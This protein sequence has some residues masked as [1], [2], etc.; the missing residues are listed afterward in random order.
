[1]THVH[2]VGAGLAGL[3]AAVAL[4]GQGRRVTLYEAAAHAGG[5]CRSFY[6]RTLGR[7]ID[8]GNHLL[9]TAN[10]AAL[11]YVQEIGATETLIG[12]AEAVFPFF[13]L[14]SGRRWSLRPN[15]GPFPWWVFASQRRVPDTRFGSYLAALRLAGAGPAATVADRISRNDPLFEPFWEPLTVAALNTPPE[16]ASAR[17]LWRLVR[18]T[19]GRGGAA[20]R[21][22]IARDGLAASLV[23]PALATVARRGGT[24]RFNHRLRAIGWTDGAADSLDFGTTRVPVAAE[25]WLVLAVPPAGAM[26][27]LPGLDAPSEAC[28]IVN[29]H[30]R[31]DRPPPLPPGLRSD[32]PM[33]GVIGGS[34]QWIFV[35]GDVISLTISAADALVD[36][37]AEALAGRLWRETAAALALPPLPR[38]PI[39]VIKER[40][41]TFAQTPAAQSL[42]P[43]TRTR[44]RNVVLAGD[45]IDTGYPA[46]IESAVR[47]GRS[48]AA[49]I[50]R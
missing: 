46:T 11:S 45:W 21:P 31:L 12:P 24:V 49:L 23:D 40:R 7:T 27:L 6:D 22:R 16:Q 44:W 1:M 5:R 29:A 18:E 26:V 42:R 3:A 15:R 38:P 39:R 14:R 17:L 32:L 48:A 43:A 25:D 37:E 20:C 33:L 4:A 50:T 8:N 36:E 30:L 28:A 13:D 10:T 35:R 47:S 34:V 41:A 2:I 9:L 19:F